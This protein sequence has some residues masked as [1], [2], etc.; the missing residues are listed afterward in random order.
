MEEE[1]LAIKENDTWDTV[2][3][4]SNVRPIGFKWD[5][6]SLAGCQ[7]SSSID[8]TLKINVEYRREE[9]NI[10]PDPTKFLQ[11]VWSLNYLSITH[12]NISFAVQQVSYFMQAPLH[13]HLVAVRRIIQYLLRISTRGLF[14]PSRSSIRLNSFSDSDWAGCPDTHRSITG[15]CMFLGE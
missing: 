4:P 2:S 10:F 6:N 7:N 3:Y 12:P 13:L 8:T 14:F 9:G 5:L 1:L 15:R 11:L